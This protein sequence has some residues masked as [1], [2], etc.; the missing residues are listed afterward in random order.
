MKLTGKQSSPIII[1]VVIIT[2]L[3][4]PSTP[5]TPQRQ[6]YR[7]R[8]GESEED[9]QSVQRAIYL[10]VSSSVQSVKRVELQRAASHEGGG[11]FGCEYAKRVM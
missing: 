7:D 11:S 1:S 10:Y 6:M 9:L 8:E 4:S 3:A 2:S 5:H